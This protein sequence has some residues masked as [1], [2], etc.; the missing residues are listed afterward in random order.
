[1]KTINHCF[2][3]II[4]LIFLFSNSLFSQEYE[5]LYVSVTTLHWNMD[6]EDFSIDEWKTGATE[7]HEW[8]DIPNITHNLDLSELA[9]ISDKII[10]RKYEQEDFV[11]NPDALRNILTIGS[12]VG[13][14]QAKILVAITREQKKENEKILAGDII[15]HI[16]VDYYIVK[17]EH[18]SQDIWNR[19][20]NYV[21]FVYNQIA[22]DIGINV[23]DSRLICEGG[24]A[25]FAS[26]RF[27]RVKNRKVHK[28]TVN[29]LTGFFGKN[30]EFSYEHI[31]SVMEHLKLPSNQ[32]E[33]LF[34]QMVFNVV[35]SN[36]DD[37]TKNFSI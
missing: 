22:K 1:M 20:K 30:T 18:D 3:G 13:G 34:M 23:A 21:E 5:P 11:H 26:K 28:Q 29:A 27:D 14:A 6:L 36:R 8:K 37:H 10:K 2:K 7:Y 31:F 24:R 9:Q 4:I 19:E 25:H 35:A 17:L 33:Q 12:S 15:H 16:P 32:K